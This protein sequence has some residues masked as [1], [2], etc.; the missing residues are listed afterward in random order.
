MSLLLLRIFKLIFAC[1]ILSF[2]FIFKSHHD[3]CESHCSIFHLVTPL[4]DREAASLALHQMMEWSTTA[5]LNLTVA[6]QASINCMQNG[7]DD[8]GDCGT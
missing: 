8:I 4:V 6:G 1:V 7:P 5:A 3:C 2:L